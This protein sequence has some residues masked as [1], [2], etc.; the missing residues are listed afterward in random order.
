MEVRLNRGQCV[1]TAGD[2]FERPE[3]RF[4]LRQE[5]VA[6]ID[7]EVGGE[8]A[9]V[10]GEL[11]VATQIGADPILVREHDPRALVWRRYVAR[12][13]RRSLLKSQALNQRVC[14]LLPFHVRVRLEH[15]A[16]AVE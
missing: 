8:N 16:A 12:D 14:E 6:G 2:A 4:D 7:D 15:A 11:H 10:E 3:D 9:E 13:C 5:R 1:I